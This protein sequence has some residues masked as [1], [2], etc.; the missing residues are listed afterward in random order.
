VLYRTVY[1][2]VSEA[3]Q[4][5]AKSTQAKDST[6]LD[7]GL[8]TYKYNIGAARQKFLCLPLVL[9]AYRATTKA[10]GGAPP[11]RQEVLTCFLSCLLYTGKMDWAGLDFCPRWGYSFKSCP[12][13]FAYGRYFC[14]RIPHWREVPSIFPTFL[15]LKR[16][17]TLV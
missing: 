9:G 16:T 1:C 4:T 7:S 8:C 13:P 3:A 12:S 14:L 17:K 11:K 6:E 15:K 10:G 2:L 5:V